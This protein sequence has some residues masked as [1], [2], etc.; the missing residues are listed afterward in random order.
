MQKYRKKKVVCGKTVLDVVVA[1]SFVKKAIGLMYRK[2][3]G[4]KDG[5]LFEFG[6]D[7][8][9]GI[10]MRNMLFPIDIVWLDSSGKVVD[11]VEDAAP[12]KGFFDCKV[13][14]PCRKARYIIE[15]NSGFVK[16]SKLCKGKTVRI[17]RLN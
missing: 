16:S 11:Y 10:W 14:K 2:R 7:G 4:R 13:Y 3:L 5:M 17:D 12:C 9:Y 6:R 8:Y 1:D 15:A